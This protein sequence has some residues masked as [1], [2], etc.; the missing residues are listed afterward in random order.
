M[1]CPDSLEVF[2]AFFCNPCLSAIAG[3]HN[4]TFVSGKPSIVT[5]CK[6]NVKNFSRIKLNI[7]PFNPGFATISSLIQVIASDPSPQFFCKPYDL[8]CAAGTDTIVCYLPACTSIIGSCNDAFTT[9]NPS[10]HCIKKENVTLSGKIDL[11][12]IFFFL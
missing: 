7:I 5:V 9:C 1:D 6:F 8:A 12:A 2:S 4:N 11:Q 10:P 3:S